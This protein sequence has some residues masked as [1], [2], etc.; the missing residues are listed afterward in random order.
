MHATFKKE[1]LLFIRQK[2][3]P[4]V[5][6]A[7]IYTSS[8]QIAFAH[9]DNRQSSEK[10]LQ[11]ERAGGKSSETNNQQ[12]EMTIAINRP[13]SCTAGTWGKW[14]DDE[15]PGFNKKKENA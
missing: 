13:K 1:Y 4:Q 8:L 10:W 7:K 12:Q 11:R 15:G 3:I 9:H 2:S 6:K 5:A 14:R